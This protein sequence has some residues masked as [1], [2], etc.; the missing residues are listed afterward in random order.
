MLTGLPDGSVEL[1]RPGRADGAKMRIK[2]KEGVTS[3]ASLKGGGG[4]KLPMYGWVQVR[5]CP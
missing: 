1:G 2:P 3:V 5:G 4:G